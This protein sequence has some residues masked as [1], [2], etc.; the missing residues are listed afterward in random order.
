M[1][2]GWRGEVLLRGQLHGGG[3]GLLLELLD[4]GRG[5]LL[6]LVQ[7]LAIF[8]LELRGDGPEL[9]HQR[10]DGTLLSQQADTGVLHFFLRGGLEFGQLLL[11]LFDRFFHT[12]FSSKIPQR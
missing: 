4:L 10:R 6:E 3:R 1:E 9:L 5:G 2:T 8:A 11:D 12:L 7:L